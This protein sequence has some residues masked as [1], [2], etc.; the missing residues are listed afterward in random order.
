MFKY[1]LFF[2]SS[3]CLRYVCEEVK[4]EPKTMPTPPR[5]SSDDN[6]DVA[7]I[8]GDRDQLSGNFRVKTPTL[9]ALDWNQ[10]NKL[11]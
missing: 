9:K 5:E 8:N 3:P 6:G 10:V 4:V 1:I 11:I 2:I 7:P